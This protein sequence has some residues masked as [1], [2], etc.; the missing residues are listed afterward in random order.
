MIKY[1][2]TSQ[3]MTTHNGFRW[4]AEKTY[5]IANPRPELCSDG[6]FHFYDSPEAAVMMNPA[7][8][9]ILN[10]R[11]WEVE[12]DDMIAHDGTKG[13]CYSMALVRE[14][15]LPQITTTQRVAIAIH[16]ALSVHGNADFK[17]WAKKWLENIDRSESVA[18]AAA[19]AAE[20]EAREAQAAAAWAAAGENYLLPFIK[21]GMEEFQ[22]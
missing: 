14:L 19:R 2:L 22:K 16:C 4:E 9:N 6:V 17:K 8:A 18:Q 5:T 21:K 7:H 10:P 12:I 13:A 15:P 20:A 11:L 3:N 1:K